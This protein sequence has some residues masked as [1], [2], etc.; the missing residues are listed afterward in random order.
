[1]NAFLFFLIASVSASTSLIKANNTS[2][3]NNVFFKIN[4][5]TQNE[6]T[7]NVYFQ[8]MMDSEGELSVNFET[9]VTNF[10]KPADDQSNPRICFAI[11]DLYK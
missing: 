8:T 2:A 6:Q 9:E 5:G 4:Q 3:V 10:K 1:M 11:R 7:I